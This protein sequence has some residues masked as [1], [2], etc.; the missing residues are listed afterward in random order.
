MRVKDLETSIKRVTT[1]ENENTRLKEKVVML[2]RKL[3]EIDGERTNAK[4]KAAVT[5]YASAHTRYASA[6]TKITTTKP[7]NKIFHAHRATMA[8][9]VQV[10]SQR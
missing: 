10:Q 7:E 6:D 2:E 3:R 5:R 8:E 4:Y 1:V 9:S